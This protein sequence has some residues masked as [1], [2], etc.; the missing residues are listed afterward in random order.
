MPPSNDRENK[1]VGYFSSLPCLILALFFCTLTGL[2][3]ESSHDDSVRK[4]L[5]TA[6]RWE[7]FVERDGV[8]YDPKE[9]V[10]YT[11][12]I[13]LRYGNEGL[14][15]AYCRDGLLHGTSTSWYPNKK[16][17]SEH[18]YASGILHGLSTTWHPNGQRMNQGDYRRGKLEGI[19]I[20]WDAS[21]NEIDRKSYRQGQPAND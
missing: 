19:W 6:P 17:R 7:D 3:N 13:A 15:L 4:I 11:G 18:T 8:M 9:S 21:G 14:A 10:P 20:S 12:P 16:K 1:V 2:A 5:L